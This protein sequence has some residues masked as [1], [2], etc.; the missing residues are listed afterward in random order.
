MNY[1]KLSNFKTLKT[2]KNKIEI[3]IKKLN[4]YLNIKTDNFIVKNN[5]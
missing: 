4:N 1:N 2:I 5:L 3:V